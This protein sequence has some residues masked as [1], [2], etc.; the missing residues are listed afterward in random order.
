MPTL[1]WLN[2]GEAMRAA[3]AVPYRLLDHVSTHGDAAAGNAKLEDGTEE[4]KCAVVIDSHPKVKHW[5][6][7]LE[8]DVAGAFWLPTSSGRF[9]PDFIC[10]LTDG[11]IF[12]VEYKGAHLRSLPSE[13]E[14]D[15]VGRLWAERSE[16]KCLFLMAYLVESGMDVRGQL[17]AIIR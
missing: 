14:K 5:V 2:R 12:V 4:F 10:E 6:R 3:D 17:D 9:F 8:S 15:Q 1:D 16:S 11:R 13:I 7:N